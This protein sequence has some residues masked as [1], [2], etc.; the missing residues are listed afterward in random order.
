MASAVMAL[1]FFFFSFFCWAFSKKKLARSWCHE[2]YF[3]PLLL[4]NPF[5]GDFFSCFILCT[6]CFYQSIWR[7]CAAG[8]FFEKKS[9]SLGACHEIVVI[10]F[11]I[12][13]FHGL[14]RYLLCFLISVCYLFYN[15][16]FVAMFFLYFPHGLC[17]KY[18]FEFV[19]CVCV[20][21]YVYD[22]VC[23]CV[24]VYVCV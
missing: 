23:V 11:E 18:F 19:V 13:H 14:F 20:C 16:N 17:K 22:W 10:G 24:C 9:R 21:V 1:L 4:G 7:Y 3:S 5:L 6:F 8:F 12:L 15:H 2:F